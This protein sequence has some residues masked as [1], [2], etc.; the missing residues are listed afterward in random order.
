MKADMEMHEG[1]LPPPRRLCF[2]SLQFFLVRCWQ[3]KTKNTGRISV[4]LGGKM[5]NGPRKKPVLCVPF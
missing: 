5:E 4:K 1:S 3:Y 2:Y